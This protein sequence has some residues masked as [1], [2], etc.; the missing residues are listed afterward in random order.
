MADYYTLASAIFP[1]VNRI[2]TETQY[3]RFVKY[4]NE[5]IE[6]DDE[7]FEKEKQIY[8]TTTEFNWLDAKEIARKTFFEADDNEAVG[9]FTD[10]VDFQDD[11]ITSKS[12][13]W[14]HADESLQTDGL[15]PCLRFL[16]H[17]EPKGTQWIIP[18]ANT[19]SR[20]RPDGFGGGVI[21]ID[22]DKAVMYD[23]EWMMDSV[24]TVLPELFTN[25]IKFNQAQNLYYT[26]AVLHPTN[27]L[28]IKKHWVVL[29]ATLETSAIPTNTALRDEVYTKHKEHTPEY[30]DV[31]IDPVLWAEAMLLLLPET[32][33][34]LGWFTFDD[35]TE[36][37]TLE[38]RGY[39]D[40]NLA[41]IYLGYILKHETDPKTQ[42]VIYISVIPTILGEDPPHGLLLEV[43]REGYTSTPVD[44]NWEP[45]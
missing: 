34:G 33:T 3:D 21:Y 28:A 7:A 43:S 11:P 32:P 45:L 22:R 36:S 20:M 27:Y 23:A 26:K 9:W 13:V 30:Y 35:E 8:D 16:I 2:A 41:G 12:S 19:C 15:L 4:L 14:I 44:A 38:A 25:W 40:V 24:N 10:Q 31:H 39:L 1:L 29:K 42:Y 37:I 6:M 17:L 18:Y 5:F